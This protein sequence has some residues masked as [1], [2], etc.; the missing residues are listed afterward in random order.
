MSVL[1]TGKQNIQ[2]CQEIFNGFGEVSG[3]KVNWEETAAVFIGEGSTPAH[4]VAMPIKWEADGEYSKLL[5]VP[6]LVGISKAMTVQKMREE[7]EAR[8]RKVKKEP[9]SFMARLS[10]LNSMLSGSQRYILTTGA[11]SDKE[12]KEIERMV[13]SLWADQKE[14]ALP[15]VNLQTLMKVN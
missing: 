5:G 11:A 2:Q 6:F 7:L 14:S 13:V 10:I 9:H 4:L 8:L 1:H 12:L 3:L 15:G